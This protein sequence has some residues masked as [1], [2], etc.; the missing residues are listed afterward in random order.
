MDFLTFSPFLIRLIHHSHYLKWKWSMTHWDW[1]RSCRSQL[2]SERDTRKPA[3]SCEVGLHN[4]TT[5]MK[6]MA[7]TNSQCS[8]LEITLWHRPDS[9][10]CNHL[11]SIRIVITEVYYFRYRCHRLDHLC[12]A[13]KPCLQ[14]TAYHFTNRFASVLAQPLTIHN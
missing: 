11:Y 3:Y 9:F 12:R 8:I 6:L 14:R 7:I 2:H 1:K 5:M 10:N 13:Y 4:L